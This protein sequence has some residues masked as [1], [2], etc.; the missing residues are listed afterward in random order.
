MLYGT[1]LNDFLFFFNEL[2]VLILNS[3]KCSR[4]NINVTAFSQKFFNK[5]QENTTSNIRKFSNRAHDELFYLS[6]IDKTIQQNF[7]I[8]S[9]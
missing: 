8:R 5:M 3:V 4:Q 7:I 6:K 9:F 2:T 1:V